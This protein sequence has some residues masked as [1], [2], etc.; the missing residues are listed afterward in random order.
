MP[1]LDVDALR[2]ELAAFERK[3][4]IHLQVVRGLA[5]APDSVAAL[6]LSPPTP[7]GD[8][9][10]RLEAERS[11]AISWR[12][13]TLVENEFHDVAAARREYQRLAER[14]PGTEWADLAA[15][16]LDRLSAAEAAPSNL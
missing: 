14:F 11:A 13:A 6:D 12:Y 15:A 8:E 4:Q 10:V 1:T 16:S 9:L 7:S 2:R 5:E 3:A